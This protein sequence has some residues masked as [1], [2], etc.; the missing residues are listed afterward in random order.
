MSWYVTNSLGTG[1]DFGCTG[2]RLA[3]VQLYSGVDL[4][5]LLVAFIL[6]ADVAE[7]VSGLKCPRHFS[8][9]P[10]CLGYSEVSHNLPQL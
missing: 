9:A 8:P 10:S 6:F 5:L 3:L 7:R 2:V 4:D 1:P